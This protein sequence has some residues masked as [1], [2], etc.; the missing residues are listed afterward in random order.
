MCQHCRSRLS[1]GDRAPPSPRSAFIRARKAENLYAR[2]LRGLARHIGVLV[3]GF[4]LAGLERVPL[5]GEA[6]RRYANAIE[7]WA[8]S[9][10]ARMVAEVAQRDAQAW[11]H[12]SAEMGRALHK[13]ITTA[14]TGAVMRRQLADQVGL[15]TSLPREA[16]ERVHRLTQEGI[17]QGRRA[18]AI[19]AEILRTGE[20]TE[21]RATLIARTE[22]SRT[23][24]ALTQ[25]RAE[26]VGSEGY[27]WR[28]S[29]D[30]DVRPSH[31]TME[32]KFVRWDSPP[33]L[34]KLTGHA[35]CL[36]N[37]RCYSEVVIPD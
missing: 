30:G 14:P 2:Q 8:Q 37:C 29:G 28:T 19:A 34:D 1:V 4:D 27:I 18:D 33:T 26:H 5:L 23:A 12:V 16:A 22:V 17:V 36:P 3:R 25:A 20:V 13:E 24:S 35:G 9:V 11:R 6:L 10:G 32:G 7:P 15:I 31:R 21:A